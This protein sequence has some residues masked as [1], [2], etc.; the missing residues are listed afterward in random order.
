MSLDPKGSSL[1]SRHLSKQERRQLR[2]Q[3]KGAQSTED[4]DKNP[5]NG[6]EH[7]DGRF[8][9]IM[10]QN[11][12]QL[13][14]FVA[15]VNKVYQEN[16]RRPA[17]FMTFVL[18]GMQSSG[19]STIMER[20]LNAVLNIVQEG[21]GTRCPLDA[22]C[23]HDSRQLTPSCELRGEELDEHRKGEKL[24]VDEVFSR[25]TAHNKDLA[26]QDT[27]S[28]KP[29][30]LTFRSASVQN[31][32]FVDTPGIISNKSTGKDNRE[33][34]KLILRNEMKKPST[35]L[36]VLLEPK[37]F[38]TN[39]IVDFCDESLGG[40]EKWIKDATFLMTKFD[41]QLEDSRSATKANAFFSEFLKNNC[42]PHLVITPTLAKEDLPPSQLFEQRLKL[43][44]GADQY[45]QDKFDLWTEGHD[46]FRVEH[47]D[48]EELCPEIQPKIGFVTAKTKMRE[49]MLKDTIERLPE[50]LISLRK[51]LDERVA[52]RKRLKDQEV[53]QEEHSLRLVVQDMVLKIQDKVLGYLD[54][55][56]QSAIKFP[57]AL[58]TLDQEI[59]EEEDSDWTDR[60]LNFHSEN[61][62]KW[63]AKVAQLESYPDEIQPDSK[64]LGGKQY[65]RAI[66]FFRVV[67]IDSLPDPYELKDLVSN[68]TGYLSGGLQH[69]NWERAMVEITKVSLKQISHPGINYLVKHV[70]SIFRRLFTVALDDIKQ[71]EE[72]SAKFKLIPNGV[73]KFLIQEFDDMLWGLLEEASK[74]VHV[75]SE[76]MYSTIDPTLPTFYV[77]K[78]ERGG[79]EGD[80]SSSESGLMK[81]VQDKIN[82]LKDTCNESFKGYLRG[83][84]RSR[85]LEKVR[86]LP[87]SRSMMITRDETDE[88]LRRSFEYIVAL[89]EFNLHVCKFNLNHHLYEGFKRCLK[90]DFLNRMAEANWKELVKPDPGV[91]NQIKILDEQIQALTDSLQDVQ[92]M[93]RS[94]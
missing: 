80:H 82:A 29:L 22:T 12:D 7:D 55:D 16:L 23:I 32:R 14:Q 63:R 34:I 11:E 92:R 69:E 75:S 13:L 61:E 35:K 65:Q 25:I 54:G 40:R 86:F 70:G 37:E 18:V 6:Q 57:G 87:D 67:M 46:L 30:H 43:I 89:L 85:A 8:K 52:N 4:A 5:F 64:F 44:T 53:Y 10:A 62:D 71:G 66:E 24:S 31:M 51:D 15:K 38:A 42:A 17:P 48:Q 73:E 56:L 20:F 91:A 28:T 78:D 41:K 79:E 72:L 36:C 76:P 90:K 88:I 50:V 1:S 2:S 58:Q 68:T 9:A 83:Q 84:N 45:E 74:H 19:K 49:V 21:T 27:F 47:G 93:Q 59:D 3:R 77:Q 39:P 33:D 94:L 81:F 60:E 26:L